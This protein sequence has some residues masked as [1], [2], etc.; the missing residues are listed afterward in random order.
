MDE[1]DELTAS[2][3]VDWTLDL[4]YRFTSNSYSIGD[5]VWYDDDSDGEQDAGE[6]GIEDVTLDLYLDSDGDGVIDDGE[7]LLATA[8]TY[9]NG[10]Y[11]FDNLANGEYI[12]DVTDENNVLAG[13][14]QTAGLDPWLVT[15][16]GASRD[17][18]DFG[19]V[20]DAGNGSIGDYVWDDADQDG[21]QDAGE[22][23]LANI[24][25]WLYE[26]EIGD[27]VIDPEDD[28][29]ATASTDS[30]GNYD[31]TSLASG[32]YI[33]DVDENDPDLPSDASLTTDNDPLSVG[34]APGEDYNHADFGFDP[35]SSTAVTLSS[36]T[37]G[38][39]RTVPVSRVATG[40]QPLLGEFG[41]LMLAMGGLVWIKRRRLDPVE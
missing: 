9:A 11:S 15:I 30:D 38:P 35:P 21:E 18:I 22:N 12:V 10:D 31:F 6:S 8:T 34:L 29:L 4:G 26:D 19:Y 2:D 3:P 16:S 33:V 25:V 27:G 23:G 37:A 40:I 17:D 36:F 32:D 13:Y 20:Y 41:L 14:G 39:V 1:S 24:T 5:Y 7:P 28:L